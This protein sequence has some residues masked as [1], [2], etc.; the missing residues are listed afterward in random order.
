MNTFINSSRLKLQLLKSRLALAVAFMLICTVG[1][2]QLFVIGSGTSTNSTFSYPAPYGQYYNGAKHQMLVLASELTGSGVTTERMF[3]S[4]AFNTASAAGA[5]LLNF[6]IK[7][8]MTTAT[9]LTTTYVTG[10]TQVYTTASYTSTSGWN[11]HTLTTPFTWD[12]TSNIVVEVCFD[13]YPN[14]YSTNAAHYYS[15]TS[16]ASCNFYYSDNGGVCATTS[17]SSTS[18]SRPNMRFAISTPVA[19]DVLLSSIVSPTSWSMGNNTLTVNVSSYGSSAMSTADLGYKVNNNTAVLQNAVAF[20]PSLNVGQSA[21][22]SFTV[23]INISTGG[24]YT[25]KVWARNPNN[26]GP[27]G[28]V[29]N[30][31]L[32]TSFCTGLSGSFTINPT[33]SG[34]SNFPSF[35][36]AVSTLA[37]CGI[38]GPVTFTVAAGT[39]NEQISIPFIPGSSATNTVTFDGVDTATRFMTY[40]V[41]ANA[42]SAVIQLNGAKYVTIKNLNITNTSTT[43]NW[44]GYYGVQFTNS[45]NYNNLLNCKISM[46]ILGASYYY[47]PIPVAICGSSYYGTGDNGNYNV[48]N[49]NRLIG[50]YFGMSIYGN[51][52]MPTLCTGNKITNNKIEQAYY[53]GIYGQYQTN[54]LIE[55]NIIRNST[56]V[57]YDYGIYFY[58]MGTSDINRNEIYTGGTGIYL[59]TYS[60]YNTGTC[61][62]NNNILASQGATTSYYGLYISN[63]NNTNILHNT[64]VNKASG[65]YALYSFISYAGNKVNNNIFMT[66]KPTTYPLYVGNAS[67]A[68]FNSFDNNTIVG[69]PAAINTAYFGGGP[70]ANL[71]SLKAANASFN[72]NNSGAT[73]LFQSA[74]DLHLSTAIEQ[75]RGLAGLGVNIDIDGDARCVFAPSIGADESGFISPV[76]TAGFTSGTV[77]V[78]SPITLLNNYPASLPMSHKWY[79]NGTFVTSNSNLLYTFPTTGTYNVALKS[80]NC[81]GSDSVNV[82]VTVVNPSTPPLSDFIASL[83]VVNTYQNVSFTDLSSNGPTAWS[84]TV[85]PGVL[86]TDYYYASGTT[87]SSQNPVI[88]FATAGNYTICLRASNSQGLGSNKCKANYVIV[89]AAQQMCVFPFSTKVSIG[90][91]YSSGGPTGGYGQNEN[92][93]FTIDACADSTFLNVSQ[94]SFGT[95]TVDRFEIYEGDYFIGAT[96]KVTFTGNSAI[97]PLTVGVKGKMTVREVTDATANNGTGIKATWYATA[98]TFTAPTGTI[99]GSSNAYYCAAGIY[100]YYSSSF[101]D[102]NYTYDWDF[103][104]D[105]ITDFTG[106]DGYYSFSATG[107]DT[108][109]LKINGCG[110]SITLTK[111]VNI[112]A[113]PTPT[114]AFNTTLFTA[115]SQDTVKLNDLSTGGVTSWK[116]TITGPGIVSYVGGTNNTSRNPKVM[117][118][119]AGTYTVK[120]VVSNCTGSDS[121]T[122]SNYF[123]ILGYCLP[124]AGNLLPDIT[125]SKFQMGSIN[126]TVTTPP[127]GTVAYRDFSQTASTNV[128][129]GATYP[130]TITRTSN[131]NSIGLKIWVDWNQDGTFDPTSELVASNVTSGMT[132]SANFFT[133]KTAA[134]GATRLRIGAAYNNM[135]NT[136]CGANV[137]GEFQDYRVI[138][139]PDVTAPVL[140]LGGANPTYVE[141]GRN[142][143]ETGDV[144]IDAVDGTVTDSIYYT[145]YIT[146]RGYQ[147]PITKQATAL[148]VFTL[149]ASSSDLSANVTVKTRT[150]IVT[151]DTTKP[152]INLNGTNPMYVEVYNSFVDPGATATDFYFT[153]AITVNSVNTVDTSK[154]GT[155]KAT[156][157]ATDINGNAAVPVI[158]TV[159][160]RDTQKPVI[161]FPSNTDTVYVEVRSNYTDA[162]A[163]V[164]DNYYKLLTATWTG[165][166]NTYVPGTYYYA[167]SAVDGSGNVANTRTRVIIVRDGTAPDLVLA[168]PSDP[169]TLVIEAKAF[170]IV[171][172]PGYVATDNYYPASQLTVSKSGSVDLNKIG[173]YVVTYVATDPAGNSSAPKRRIYKLVDTTKPVIKLNGSNSINIC[174]WRPYTDAGASVTDN[175]W[176]GLQ[177]VTNSN[178]D[179]NLPG[180]YIITYTA[181]DSSGNVALPVLRYVNVLDYTSSSCATFSGINTSGSAN[182]INVTPNPSN[183]LININIAFDSE[184]QS[185][186]VIYNSLGQIVKVVD[187]AVITSAKYTVNMDDQASG[188]YFVTVKSDNKT[189]T[190]KFVLNK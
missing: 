77:Y 6:T 17:A 53:M 105:G 29:N 147:Q 28:N 184:N 133:P 1:F 43:Y 122:I 50:G 99:T 166:V 117:A 150:V 80:T 106:M 10:L 57:T 107:P 9:A 146:G 56:A 81:S 143:V 60:Y 2:S 190:K 115:T 185:E 19:N 113:P 125:V 145:G 134:L 63:T 90:N 151:P 20:S 45:A 37:N 3:Q 58:Y 41:A 89:Q 71:T 32:V 170:T 165:S 129:R 152:V 176:N 91:L 13:N 96:P 180:I 75:A 24:S 161:V 55:H 124:T 159:I 67:T 103:D 114:A 38:S 187:N 12:G 120:L 61:N 7:M 156:Y 139:R 62:I 178:L 5:P 142:F 15:T 87:A 16:F 42:N 68:Y 47:Y 168:S 64:V 175:Y 169:D 160:V 130:F 97:V 172:E 104:N 86:N 149:D 21:N 110:G 39:Y 109:K 25:L 136:P 155:Y 138:V 31:T 183:G 52:T 69:D 59:Y 153:T 186:I 163:T 137:Y 173:I 48:I 112:I 177:V 4:V 158:R 78:N 121:V 140:T 65:G 66:T 44:N 132:W 144:S 36:S 34:S 181:V 27:D 18:T 131:Y 128:D 157:T 167:F 174:R 111:F 95:G 188:I 54:M 46:P 101:R 85:S 179:M 40:D 79:V 74:T 33:G 49:N 23:P 84:W 141:I 162:G 102:P 73:P 116:W 30:D 154:L 135:S 82:V 108:I 76:P 35:T 123:K 98:G 88:Y 51:S 92:C 127:P 8:G 22:K 94:A 11:V 189:F 14:G 171:P 72:Q 119:I 164:T 26:L 83:S 182:T 70:Y 126:N 148:G 100:N 118:A 93:T